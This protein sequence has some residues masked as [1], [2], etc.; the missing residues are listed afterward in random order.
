MVS[1]DVTVELLDPDGVKY[2]DGISKETAYQTRLIERQ[3]L[4]HARKN[5]EFMHTVKLPSSCVSKDN[6]A[7][8]FAFEDALKQIK[9]FYGAECEYIHKPIVTDIGNLTINQHVW[10]IAPERF[11]TREA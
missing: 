10:V 4:H 2:K 6:E 1:A 8:Y 11:R 9:E 3:N 5:R 7:Q